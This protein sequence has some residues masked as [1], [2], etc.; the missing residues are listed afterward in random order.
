MKY[1]LVTV[2][3][4]ILFLGAC[5]SQSNR[6]LPFF[7]QN[8]EL[9]QMTFSVSEDGKQPLITISPSDLLSDKASDR[10]LSA[11]TQTLPIQ[12]VQGRKI[13]LIINQQ[14]QIIGQYSKRR[15]NQLEFYELGQGGFVDFYQIKQPDLC[16]NFD[17]NKL[18]NASHAITFYQQNAHGE[19]RLFGVVSNFDFSYKEL[20]KIRHERTIPAHIQGT[21][22][23]GIS[24][25][26]N[27]ELLYGSY[28]KLK[29]FLNNVIC[30]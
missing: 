4:A 22:A 10:T 8:G 20:I 9:Q 18:L 6:T 29:S 25:Q 27:S 15:I 3:S 26:D 1:Q 30:H 12:D 24:T 11:F 19:A 7:D 23:Q 13:L 21:S 14:P 28:R 16:T 5:S 17:K 2:L